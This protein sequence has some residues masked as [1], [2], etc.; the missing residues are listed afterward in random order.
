MRFIRFAELPGRTFIQKSY[1]TLETGRRIYLHVDAQEYWSTVIVYTGAALLSAIVVFLMVFVILQRWK[2]QT[3]LVQAAIRD[4]LTG[5]FTRLY[6]QEWLQD[7]I[8]THARYP[9]RGFALLLFDVDHFKSINDTYGHVV[10]DEVLRGIAKIIGG[11]IRGD[12]IAVRFGGEEIAVFARADDPAEVGPL[13]ERIR[14]QVEQ[15]GVQTSR[16]HVAM[17]LS[18]GIAVHAIGESSEELF[19]RADKKLYEAKNTGRNRVLSQ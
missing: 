2:Y 10:G 7:A 4:S 15:Q 12:D 19:E 6:M 3:Q 5:L 9:E 16:G 1:D 8:D 17:T 13:G 18:G 14:R 11:A